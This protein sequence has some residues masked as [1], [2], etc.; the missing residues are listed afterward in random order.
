MINAVVGL[1]STFLLPFVV[2]YEIFTNNHYSLEKNK[3]LDYN[4]LMEKIT[5]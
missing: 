4:V 2:N 1:H 3:R 5:F